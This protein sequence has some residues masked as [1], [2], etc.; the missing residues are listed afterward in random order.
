MRD[1]VGLDT[2]DET[3]APAEQPS[4]SQRKRDALAVR[5]LAAELVALDD[6]HLRRLPL[7]EAIRRAVLDARSI[8]SHIARKR[9]LQYLAR[10]LRR[11]DV[12]AIGDAM[13]SFRAEAR[14][15]TVR[16]RRAEAWRDRLLSAGD[17]ALAELIEARPGLDAQSIR[18]LQRSANREARDGRPP[19]ASRTL[20]RLLRDL[21]QAEPLPA[22]PAAR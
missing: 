5:A 8:R 2:A 18:Q 22:C 4:K 20:F 12:T 19:A 13:A 11:E 17:A 15:L 16:H 6:P 1:P 9:Q 7:D 21:D 14:Q 10:L 3:G